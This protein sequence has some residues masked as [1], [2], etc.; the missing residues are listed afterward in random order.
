MTEPPVDRPPVRPE[1]A[2]FAAEVAAAQDVLDAFMSAW[3]ARDADGVRA[4]FNFPH[5]RFASGQVRVLSPEQVNKSMYAGAALT[6]WGRS[7]W[8]RREVIHAGADKVQFDT[9]FARYRPDGTLIS[10]FDSIYIVTLQ[11]GRWGIQGRS[12]Y[13]P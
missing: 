10:A 2:A 5:V 8:R 1:H 6:E 3:N 13:A 11:D 9:R 7:A 12:S 4:S